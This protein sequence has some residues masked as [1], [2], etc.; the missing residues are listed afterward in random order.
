MDA[1]VIS[2]FIGQ[3]D[4]H[5]DNPKDIHGKWT[6]KVVLKLDEQVIETIQSP[7]IY[8]TKEIAARAMHATT[9]KIRQEFEKIL[10]KPVGVH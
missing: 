8:E 1:V 2:T 3:I 7:H 5:P 9:T 10:G 6:F 4:P